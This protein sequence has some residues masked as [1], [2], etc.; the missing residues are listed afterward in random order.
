MLEA[1]AI[2]CMTQGQGTLWP[3]SCLQPKQEPP[4]KKTKN[5]K[6]QQQKKPRKKWQG[7]AKPTAANKRGKEKMRIELDN[8]LGR[9]GKHPG[10]R[11]TPA[12]RVRY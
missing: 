11:V 4:Q 8:R 7:E 9:A 12:L 3:L 1:E 6:Q 2:S 10:S 5:Q